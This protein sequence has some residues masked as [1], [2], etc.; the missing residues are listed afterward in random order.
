VYDE[1]I[2]PNA[3]YHIHA[4][5]IS[6]DK[7]VEANYSAALVQQTSIWGDVVGDYDP[8]ACVTSGK[9]KIYVDC[10]TSPD[11][12]VTF[13]DISATVDKFKNAPTAPQKSRADIAP[14]VVDHKVD[15]TDIPAVVDGFRGLPYPYD[16]AE[17]C[18]P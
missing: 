11:G 3:E 8:G 4:I 12:L 14:G 10:W 7:G 2:I 9:P 17:K 15:F 5:D 13:A 1:Q 16:P 18:F 6:C